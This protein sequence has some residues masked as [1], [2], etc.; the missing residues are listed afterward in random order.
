M[1]LGELEFGGPKM[2]RKGAARGS[3]HGICSVLLQDSTTRGTPHIRVQ[4]QR[5]SFFML[6]AWR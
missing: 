3:S 2:G 6:L 4:A 1:K 5:G